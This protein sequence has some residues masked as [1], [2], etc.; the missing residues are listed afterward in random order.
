[1]A[2]QDAWWFTTFRHVCR[3]AREHCSA[4]FILCKLVAAALGLAVERPR[5]LH[6]P[7]A[8]M[9]PSLDLIEQQ[10]TMRK[11][12]TELSSACYLAKGWL[13]GVFTQA[14]HLPLSSRPRT[15]DS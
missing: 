3:K 9:Q 4:G 13:D 12:E 5:V 10:T 8:P 2:G 15:A 1:M 11:A 7:V 6:C 14:P